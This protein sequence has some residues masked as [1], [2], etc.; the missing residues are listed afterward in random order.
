[1]IEAMRQDSARA[2]AGSFQNTQDSSPFLR[3]GL[4]WLCEIVSFFL[5]LSRWLA[6]CA[7]KYFCGFRWTSVEKS[8]SHVRRCR[9]IFTVHETRLGCFGIDVSAK[10]SLVLCLRLVIQASDSGFLHLRA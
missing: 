6:V 5:Q 8:R 9:L 2:L 4:V 1:M 10:V 3:L 7:I